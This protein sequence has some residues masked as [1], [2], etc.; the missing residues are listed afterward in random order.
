MRWNTFGRSA[1]F[2]ALAGCG[3]MLWLGLA[4][5]LLG[6]RQALLFYMVAAMAA[7]VIGIAPSPRRG[8]GP[9]LLVATLGGCLMLVAHAPADLALGLAVL[10]AIAR[11]GLLYRLRPGRTVAVEG[12]LVAC[13]LLFARLLVG[14]SLLSVMLAVW[15]FLL[16]QSLFFLVGGVR[17]REPGAAHKDPF[18]AA[19]ERANALL[20]GLAV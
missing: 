3:V 20:D 15:G 7:Y 1:L 5:P 16:V 13:G 12:A 10:L 11:G 8:L 2:S 6:V 19:Y 18:D 14:S 17:E 4:A 9:G